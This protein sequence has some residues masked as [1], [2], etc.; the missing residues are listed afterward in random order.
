MRKTQLINESEADVYGS[1]KY[2][3]APKTDSIG[4]DDIDDEDDADIEDEE[5]DDEDDDEIA[6][7]SVE[8][9]D[10]DDD[11]ESSPSEMDIINPIDIGDDDDTNMLDSNEE[12]IRFIERDLLKPKIDRYKYEFKI[13]GNPELYVGIPMAKTKAGKYIFSTNG[14]YKSFNIDDVVFGGED[15]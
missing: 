12:Y 15:E 13:K 3:G 11:D 1:V 6:V 14:A 9:D 10:E 5:F 4:L 8:D 7:S 2:V